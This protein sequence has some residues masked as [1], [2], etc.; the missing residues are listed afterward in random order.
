MDKGDVRRLRGQIKALERRLRRE[1]QGVGELPVTSLQVLGAVERSGVAMTPGELTSELQMTTSNVAASLR[2][3]E[4][5][6]AVRRRRDPDDG[7]RVFVEA[8]DAGRDLVA[9]YRRGRD[10]W[11]WQTVEAVLTEGEQRLLLQA[12]E[13]MQRLADHVPT[14]RE[15]PI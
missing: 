7:R 12:G 9:D 13:L 15:I 11:F 10:A 14:Q 1:L 8:T 3:L 6:G 4:A 5:A 2:P